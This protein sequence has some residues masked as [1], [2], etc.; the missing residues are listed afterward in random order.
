MDLNNEDIDWKFDIEE[1]E[2]YE[3]QYHDVYHHLTK[4]IDRSKKYKSP[5]IYIMDY[6]TRK[7]IKL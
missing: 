6:D 1:D 3:H 7:L 5:G 2:I 4:M